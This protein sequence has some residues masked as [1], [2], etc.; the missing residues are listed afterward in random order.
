[1][2]LQVLYQNE[3]ITKK[4]TLDWYEKHSAA[5]SKT[6]FLVT[7]LERLENFI[8][9]LKKDEESSDESDSDDESNRSSSESKE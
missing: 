9:W 5:E 6:E 2:I 8:N 3:I 7:T 1:M 4:G